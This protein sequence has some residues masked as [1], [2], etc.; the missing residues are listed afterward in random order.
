MSY[1]DHYA[2]VYQSEDGWRFRIKGA[3]HEIMAT[4]ESYTTKASAIT[5][6]LRVHPGIDIIEMTPMKEA[7]PEELDDD[8]DSPG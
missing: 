7:E 2:E 6:V 3:N 5:G 1:E 8:Q 4:G